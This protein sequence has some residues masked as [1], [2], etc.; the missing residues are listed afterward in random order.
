MDDWKDR[1]QEH[2]FLPQ[3]FQA[4]FHALMDSS[5][6][7]GAH[8]GK[9]Q[10]KIFFNLPEK[11]ALRSY[12]YSKLYRTPFGADVIT[13][14]NATEFEMNVFVAQPTEM[15]PWIQGFGKFARVDRE[16]CPQLYEQLEKN[17]Q[18]LKKLYESV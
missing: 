9:T 16:I 13:Q 14:K 5:W 3:L 11:E 10:V 18:E 2:F 7:V 4:Y 8:T 6:N 15:I 17:K 12:Y 1:I